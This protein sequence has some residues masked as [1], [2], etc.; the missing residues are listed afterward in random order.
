V[1][2]EILSNEV[3]ETVINVARKVFL[4]YG[5]K[6]TS[7]DDIAKAAKLGKGTIY[8]YFKSKEEVFM[9]VIQ[10][11]DSEVVSQMQAKLAKAKGIEE[12]LMIY[13]MEPFKHF[14]ADNPIAYYSWNEEEPFFLKKLKLLKGKLLEELRDI[15]S[16]IYKEAEQKGILRHNVVNNIEEQ[17]EA[18]FQLFMLS[19]DHLRNIQEDDDIK[20]VINDFENIFETFVNGLI[21]KEE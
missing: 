21:K 14:E 7:I 8:Y 17:V 20:K 3:Y 19:N 12:K 6:K 11:N 2:E 4:R 1:K 13:F 15:L 9:A 18:G 5:Y 16:S 10:K